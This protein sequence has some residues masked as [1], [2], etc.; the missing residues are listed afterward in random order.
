[1]DHGAGRPV[2]GQDAE[3]E[4]PD[5]LEI[6]QDELEIAQD[7]DLEVGQDEKGR[8][9]DGG[10][11][12]APAASGPGGRP[13]ADGPVATPP[14]PVNLQRATIWMAVGTAMSR[15]TG[16]LRIIALAYALGPFRLADG[17]NLANTAP[18]M[19]Y[20]IVIGGVLAATFIPVFVD[21]LANRS[22][23]DAWRAISAVVTVSMVVLTVAS[24]VFW[25]AAPVVISAV[26]ALDPSHGALASPRRRPANATWP[27]ACSAGSCPRSSSTASSA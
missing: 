5:E 21:R 3:R 16:V 24:I 4:S 18:N 2:A 9:P 17:Y 14:A 7:A 26:T 13:G 1:M 25:F 10:P 6:A 8:R 23:R 27:R 22:E 20:D 15:L 19:L 12:G 11:D